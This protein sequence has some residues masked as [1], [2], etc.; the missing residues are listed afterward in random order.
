MQ[1]SFLQ[2]IQAETGA[3]VTLRGKGSGFIEITGGEA[4][5][6]MHIH[7][8]Y[9]TLSVSVR[10]RGQSWACFAHI[11]E[12]HL[13]AFTSTQISLTLYSFIKFIYIPRGIFSCIS[14]EIAMTST[15]KTKC[16]GPF[17]SF[18]KDTWKSALS[19]LKERS[20]NSV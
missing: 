16:L 17:S 20:R 3:K 15:I 8:Q 11:I 13:Q 9:V 12:S 18:Y 6:P 7:L 2:H 19:I 14:D 5:E 1:G 10:C 4:M